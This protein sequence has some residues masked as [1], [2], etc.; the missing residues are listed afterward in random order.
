MDD[1]LHDRL[2]CGLA[3][4]KFCRRLLADADCTTTFAKAVELAQSFEQA[5]KNAKAV[6]G[7]EAAL[8]NRLQSPADNGQT[9]VSNA[10][11]T[12]D[13]AKQIMTQRIAVL[14]TLLAI[15]A[16]RK[17][18]SPLFGEKR[19]ALNEPLTLNML[20]PRPVTVKLKSSVSM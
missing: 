15:T 10:S 4:T 14:L 11:C 3:S 17:G 8:K 6:K 12:T 7:V 5:D 13:V 16:R 1:G 19:R 9:K 18:I 2:V 20:H